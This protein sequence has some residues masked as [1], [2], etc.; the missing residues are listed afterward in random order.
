MI[1]I[2]DLFHNYIERRQRC[3]AVRLSTENI[4][5]VDRWLKD[6][7]F[8]TKLIALN[9]DYTLEVFFRDDPLFTASVYAGDAI[10]YLDAG[11]VALIPGKGFRSDWEEA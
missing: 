4:H 11:N 10:Q 8:G 1:D 6:Q 5:L 7:G 9:G 2:D 3:K